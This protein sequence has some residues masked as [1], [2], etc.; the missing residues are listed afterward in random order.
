MADRRARVRELAAG[1]I[2]K[3]DADFESFTDGQTSQVL[4]GPKDQL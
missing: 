3:G 4:A 1:Y 2:R